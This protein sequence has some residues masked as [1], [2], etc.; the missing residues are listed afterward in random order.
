VEL[1]RGADPDISP[2]LPLRAEQLGSPDTPD[3]PQ[4]KAPPRR[5]APDNAD[6]PEDTGPEGRSQ[7]PATARHLPIAAVIAESRRA[8]RRAGE[9]PR[10]QRH[11]RPYGRSA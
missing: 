7:V 10:F 8:K 11:Q 1:A 3:R 5:N 6:Q 9:V 4:L 2:E